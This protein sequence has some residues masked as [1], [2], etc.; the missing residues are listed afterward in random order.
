MNFCCPVRK[1]LH[2]LFLNLAGRLFLNMKICPRNGE[3]QHIRRL[4]IGNFFEHRH[5]FGNIEKLCKLNRRHRFA[6]RRSP[7]VKIGQ[8]LFFQ[9]VILQIL[10]H[11][12][13]FYHRIADRCS[14]C[15]GYALSACDFIEIP[16][17]HIKVGGLLRFGLRDT[18]H[19]PHFC[20]CGE[21]FVKVCLIHK[22]PI[23]TLSS[24]VLSISSS[25]SLCSIIA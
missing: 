15:K 21:V 13:K 10:L 17:L 4:Y 24:E 5:E 20:I 23:N 19:I 25:I 18:C 6:E 9:R 16:T 14:R 8:S 22:K 11:G 12:I 7:C 2:H 1:G 3:I